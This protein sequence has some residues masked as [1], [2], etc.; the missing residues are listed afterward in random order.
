MVRAPVHVAHVAHA[1]MAALIGQRKSQAVVVSGDRG[2]GKTTAARDVVRCAMMQHGASGGGAARLQQRVR[3]A[4]VVLDAFVGAAG[5]T[6]AGV[7]TTLM[8]VV[9]P[10]SSDGG[11]S[12][13]SLVGAEVTLFAAE[14][15]RVAAPPPGEHN[16][17]VFY[18]VQ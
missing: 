4:Q 7:A 11:G 18:Q 6:R 1:A 5:S 13:A 17:D 12:E 16:M 8:F 3:A 14:R 2:A 10:P 9:H 15:A